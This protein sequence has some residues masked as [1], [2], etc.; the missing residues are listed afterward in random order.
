MCVRTVAVR[1][2]GGGHPAVAVDVVVVGAHIAG[3]VRTAY[4]C[5][6]G[7][8]VPHETRVAHGGVEAQVLCGVVHAAGAVE[9][10]AL[11]VER[12]DDFV[13]GVG[14]VA[15]DPDFVIGRVDAFH[16]DLV[17]EDVGL[18]LIVVAAVEH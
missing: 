17:D 2:R 16:P 4:E 3:V 11:Q 12:H 13:A 15:I 10:H 6:V 7:R 14:V 9:P 18:D 1:R 5:V 8:Y